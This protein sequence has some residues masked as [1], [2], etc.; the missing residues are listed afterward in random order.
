MPCDNGIVFCRSREALASAL[1]SLGRY[2]VVG[3]EREPMLFTPNMS[4]SAWEWGPSSWPS[5]NP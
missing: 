5:R 4:S 2:F 1:R 3:V